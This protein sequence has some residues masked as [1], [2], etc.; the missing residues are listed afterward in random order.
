MNSLRTLLALALSMTALP[1]VVTAQPVLVDMDT[2]LRCSAAFSIVASEQQRGVAA[3]KADYPPLSERGR[4]FFVQTGARLMDERKLTRVQVQA[5]LQ[6]EVGQ[7]QARAIAAS[8][9]AAFRR[10]LMTPCLA[11]LDAA[12]PSQLPPPR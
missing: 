12:L 6:A 8:D 4:E 3:A 7:L 1:A 11:L 9:P 5:R 2:A 10:T